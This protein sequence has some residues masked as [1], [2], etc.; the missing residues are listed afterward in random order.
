MIVDTMTI[1]EVGNAVLKTA[2]ANRN[3]FEAIVGYNQ[4]AYKKII[5]RG[6]KDRYDFKTI[7][8]KADG[9]SFYIFPYSE[10]KKE[11]K[12]YGVAYTVI[13]HFFYNGTNWYC[14]LL[15]SMTEV[16]LYVQHFFQRYIERHLKI[17]TPVTIDII[18][19]YF[20][21]TNCSSFCLRKENPRHPNCMYGTTN[22]GLCCGFMAKNHFDVWLTFIDKETIERGDKYEVYNK[23]E[24]FSIPIGRDNSG[25]YI[26][27]FYYQPYPEVS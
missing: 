26:Y 11:F 1:E 6:N 27:P 17:E 8:V 20:K 24:R 15:E 7:P 3:R 18:R 16:G 2:R 22:I 13:A 25:N 5:Y 19:Q 9:I 21:E 10:G 12:K 23:T 4:P 14:Q